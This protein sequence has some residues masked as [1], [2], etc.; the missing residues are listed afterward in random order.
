VSSFGENVVVFDRSWSGL[1][2]VDAGL[3]GRFIANV[4]RIKAF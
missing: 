1:H 3:V 2:E 4:E